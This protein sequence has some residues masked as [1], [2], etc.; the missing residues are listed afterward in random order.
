MARISYASESV[1]PISI[2]APAFTDVVTDLRQLAARIVAVRFG[3]A[4][5]VAALVVALAGLGGRQ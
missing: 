2:A 5:H 4:P 3:L 1:Q